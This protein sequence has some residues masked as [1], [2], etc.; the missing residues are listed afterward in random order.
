MFGRVSRYDEH[1]T[2]RSAYRD[3]IG[4]IT[5]PTELPIS[6][7]RSDL[8]PWKVVLPIVALFILVTS[9]SV[10]LSSD[11]IFLGWIVHAVYFGLLGAIVY[12]LCPPQKNERVEIN[13]HDVTFECLGVTGYHVERVPLT[14]YRGVIPI[15]YVSVNDSGVSYKE[16]G[17]A[18]R[19]ADP[20]KTVLL[21]LNPI[22]H[23]GLVEHYAKL[24]SL[25][26]LFEEKFTL[27]L[28][29][30]KTFWSHPIEL[31]SRQSSDES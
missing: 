20:T 4:R 14:Q 27:H 30:K 11:R 8:A 23:D 15:T 31:L 5:Y 21:T 19:H 29:Q 6:A 26:P 10:K 1:P 12:H 18:L 2:D 25:K 22:R 28:V 17:A 13:A 9:A 16:Y 7:E 3:V 24:L